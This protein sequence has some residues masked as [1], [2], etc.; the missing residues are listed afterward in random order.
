MISAIFTLIAFCVTILL[1]I[2]SIMALFFTLANGELSE[3]AFP[4]WLMFIG[5]MFLWL[6]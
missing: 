3:G 6:K 4:V 1:G 2:F 5:A